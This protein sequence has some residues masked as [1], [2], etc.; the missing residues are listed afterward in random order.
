M[1]SNLKHRKILN[2]FKMLSSS[3]TS[4]II[5]FLC[6]CMCIHTSMH[7]YLLQIK[8]KDHIAFVQENSRSLTFLHREISLEM[9][10]VES[11]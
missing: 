10:I 5:P 2:K 3:K 11:R 7:N 9:H 8:V 4:L 6:M 1:V